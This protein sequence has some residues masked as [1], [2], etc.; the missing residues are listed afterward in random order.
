M[1]ELPSNL[2][3]GKR[4][5]CLGQE[6]TVRQRGDI[7]KGIWGQEDYL[8]TREVDEQQTLKEQSDRPKTFKI[9]WVFLLET[10][11]FYS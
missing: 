10:I 8:E 1:S 2:E 5:A 9:K 7:G 11:D 4:H 3:V 6:G